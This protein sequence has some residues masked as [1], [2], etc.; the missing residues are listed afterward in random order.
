MKKVYY[1]IYIK[2]NT[3]KY[4]IKKGGKSESV[5]FKQNISS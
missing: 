2:N 5:T 4:L 3:K 1:H